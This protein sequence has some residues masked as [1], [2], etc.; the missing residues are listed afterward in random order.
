MPF[1][2]NLLA[3]ES[4]EFT[5]KNVG[6]GFKPVPTFFSVNSVLSAANKFFGNGI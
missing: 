4:T 1:P 6:A 5:E 2:K 3:A